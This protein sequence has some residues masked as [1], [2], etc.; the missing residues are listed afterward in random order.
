M[1]EFLKAAFSALPSVA[2]SPYALAAFIV[3]VL[4]FGILGWKTLRHRQL[5]VHIHKLRPKDQLQAL[6]DE[7][8]VISLKEGLTP[9]QYLKSNIHRYYFCAFAIICFL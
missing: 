4:A 1:G 7:M 3:S 8:G 6:R 5:L 9:E 2:A